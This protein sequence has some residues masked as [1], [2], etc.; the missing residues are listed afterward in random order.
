MKK[1]VIS[2]M[3]CLIFAVLACSACG[4][5]EQTKTNVDVSGG[6]PLKTDSKLTYWVAMN[7]NVSA[8]A[9][10]IA[11]TDFARELTRR[12]GVEVEYIHPP[13]GQESEMFSLM[14]ASD[15][16]AD[17]VENDWLRLLGGPSKS[18]NDKIILPLGSYIDQYAPNLKEYLEN[19]PEVD[20]YVKTDEGEYYVFPLIRSDRSLMISYGPVVRTDWLEDLSLPMPE[21]VQDW[22]AMLKAFRDEKG[23]V[24]PL[25]IKGSD[26]YALYILLGSSE[27]FYIEDGKVKFGPLEPQF[28]NATET[29]HRWYDEKL[30]D[31]N[32]ALVDAVTLDYN[33]LNGQ[34]GATMISGGSGLGKWLE[35]MEG[36]DGRFNLTGAKYPKDA[37]GNPPSTV[38]FQLPY[39]G[40]GSVAISVSCEHPELAA[41]FLD[42]GYSE[43]GHMLFNFGIEGKSYEMKDGQAVYTDE[44]MKNADGLTVSQAMAKYMRVN[45]AGPFV[46]DKQYIMQ[47]YGREQQRQALE[48]WMSDYDYNHPRILPPLTFTTEEASEANTLLNDVKKHLSTEL[49]AFISGKR[50]MD[51]YDGFISEI[52]NLGAEKIVAIY[53]AAYERYLS[54]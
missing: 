33:M 49:T 19:N 8:V 25:S 16:L 41:K 37:S 53:Q 31:N 21:S 10:N 23:A 34:S 5:G 27:E 47:Y 11:D 17:I 22:E 13:Q 12:T 24:A 6:Y 42:Y 45:Y 52:K 35:T 51:T 26:R 54:R 43:E 40:Y 3:V 30:L 32:Y 2:L 9:A 14:I 1:R 18:I 36:K 20:K 7:A 38:P 4:K 44:I 28:K 15:E 46:Q 29:L 39:M 50:G 48:N